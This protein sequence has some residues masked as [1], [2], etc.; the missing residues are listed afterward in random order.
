[1][2]L[3]FGV[4]PVDKFW[5]KPAIYGKKKE[6][7]SQPDKIYRIVINSLQDKELTQ[8]YHIRY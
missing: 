4:K 3:S 6:I 7:K 8:S 1:M 5:K 2:A